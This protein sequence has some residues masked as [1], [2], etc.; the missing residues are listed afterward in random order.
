MYFGYNILYLTPSLSEENKKK[1]EKEYM[2]TRADNLVYQ[3][4]A[5]SK[6]FNS[7][8]SLINI[9]LMKYNVTRKCTICLPNLSTFTNI[10][11]S[12]SL[13]L[14]GEWV[15]LPAIISQ[16]TTYPTSININTQKV[17]IIY[18]GPVC[19]ASSKN[20]PIFKKLGF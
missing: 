20:Q 9:W 3:L 8:K 12:G 16:V 7:L 2:T 14:I 5:R 17:Y 18:T 4:G 11:L 1:T 13:F 6:L 10:Q 19:F 15:V